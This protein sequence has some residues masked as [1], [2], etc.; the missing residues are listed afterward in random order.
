MN[1]CQDMKSRHY[2][3]HRYR[4]C[5]PHRG[6]AIS[7][8]KIASVASLPRNDAK[9]GFL[10]FLIFA[11]TLLSA[12]W[13]TGPSALRAE[14]NQTAAAV[15]VGPAANPE[16]NGAAQFTYPPGETGPAAA[17]KTYLPRQKKVYAEAGSDIESQISAGLL[18][19]KPIKS[20]AVHFN[21]QAETPTLTLVLD[22]GGKNLA[23]AQK[24][25]MRFL[26]GQIAPQISANNIYLINEKG[27]PLGPLPAAA[28]TPENQMLA[29]LGQIT[30]AVSSSFSL[31]LTSQL[32]LLLFLA[33]NFYV[34]W[35]FA[36]VR[37]EQDAHPIR[38]STAEKAA[39]EF[40]LNKE[41]RRYGLAAGLKN[42]FDQ[43]KNES[44]RSEVSPAPETARAE[45]TDQAAIA[46][47]I[48][49]PA[50]NLEEKLQD[51]SPKDIYA[52]IAKE[53]SSTVAFILSFL[54]PPN[55]ELVIDLFPEE[56]REEI[57]SE[58][59][60]LGNVDA[61]IIRATQKILEAPASQLEI[62]RPA[63]APV[64][65]AVSA[66]PVQPAPALVNYTPLANPLL[67][68]I[69][70]LPDWQWRAALA[71]ITPQLAALSLK[72][73]SPELTKK[74]FR[75]LPPQWKEVVAAEMNLADVVLLKD[76]ETAQH[77]LV[78]KIMSLRYNSNQ[79]H[80]N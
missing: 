59:S 12:F 75:N 32:I 73:A 57:R 70:F 1:N 9:I 40:I 31:I 60:R 77:G 28:A 7:F 17:P 11:L 50:G 46:E 27:F 4:H 48:A 76:V 10:A 5:E 39:T 68:E 71:Q 62:K 53:K 19:F 67:E 26:I 51:L 66:K 29:T 54:E 64:V 55:E 61:E 58:F 78:E 37:S 36:H 18:A 8:A 45:Q 47:T 52:L 22:L 43:L 13:L 63:A 34:L 33:A 15:S 16:N 3:P 6:E 30:A 42:Q 49:P 23:Q 56:V 25:S 80:A 72:T 24:D 2:G 14:D 20:A 41:Q 74:V 35:K 65:R 38:S 79:S 69:L 21:T 44:D